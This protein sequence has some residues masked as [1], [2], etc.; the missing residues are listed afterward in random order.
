MAELDVPELVADATAEGEQQPGRPSG[1]RPGSGSCWPMALPPPARRKRRPPP[2]RQATAAAAAARD[3][4]ARTRVTS[5]LTGEVQ[6][7]LVQR[8][9]RVEAGRAL[10]QVVASDTLD[11]I[12]PVPAAQL[13]RLRA[14]LRR[15]RPAGGRLRSRRWAR[16]RASP[17]A[18][19]SLTNAGE[20]VIR[21]PNPAAGSSPARPRR[22]EMRL[23][24]DATC[25]SSPIRR[26]CS[27]A[28]AAVVFVVGRDSIAHQ[29]AGEPRRPR[30]RPHGDR[31][32]TSAP[33]T[34]S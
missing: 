16:D 20:V 2:R 28:T 26:W 25:W 6:Q 24:A 17:P 10:V 8:G 5:P 31:R 34:G 19:D 29:R 12:V 21:V 22:R 1:K 3:L 27:P 30:R 7:V 13:P 11:L 15:D 23:G 18:V 33:A 32:E 14:G 4:L 9:E